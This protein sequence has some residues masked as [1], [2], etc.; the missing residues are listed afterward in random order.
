MSAKHAERC[1][2]CGRRNRRSSQANALYWVLL[3][4]AAEKLR[5]DKQTYSAEQYHYYFR[6]KFIGCNDFNLPGGKTLT[7]PKSTADLDVA[8]FSDYYGKVEADLAER[9]VYLADL[10]A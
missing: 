3:H 9:G 6:S 2:T 8:E 1:P 5:P 7:I 4:A 10:P